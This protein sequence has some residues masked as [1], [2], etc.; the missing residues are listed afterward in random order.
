MRHLTGCNCKIIE[1]KRGKEK[2][3][4]CERGLCLCK[5]TSAI[6]WRTAGRSLWLAV[7]CRFCYQS[8][9]PRNALTY[10]CISLLSYSI[11]QNS[12]YLLSKICK[13]KGE[14][15]SEKC[16]SSKPGMCLCRVDENWRKK[17]IAPTT[18]TKTQKGEYREVRGKE[19]NTLGKDKEKFRIGPLAA[20][21][22][23]V[24]EDSSKG[25]RKERWKLGGCCIAMAC[26]LAFRSM[27]VTD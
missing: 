15:E 19:E 3:I 17:S 6:G 22:E 11:R 20:G 7:S 5:K 4:D 27:N 13:D 2:E 10:L 26:V 21:N 24:K 8:P 9:F 1:K 23:Q 12:A 25:K 16:A 14:I 18:R